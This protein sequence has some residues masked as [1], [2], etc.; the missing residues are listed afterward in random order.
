LGQSHKYFSKKVSTLLRN[1]ANYNAA[2]VSRDFLSSYST[3]SP[4]ILF[5]IVPWTTFCPS[6]H[7]R[8]L[9]AIL[10]LNLAEAE[11]TDNFKFSIIL[12]SSFSAPTGG[13]IPKIGGRGNRI[14]QMLEVAKE[15]QLKVTLAKSESLASLVSG[16]SSIHPK[17]PQG[18]PSASVSV[19]CPQA[20]YLLFYSCLGQ[21]LGA[22]L[23]SYYGFQLYSLSQQC[24]TP[25]GYRN[26][27]P[28]PRRCLSWARK[29]CSD[30]N[31]TS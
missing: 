29:L 7:T 25:L 18:T 15:Q 27:L 21:G 5:D 23:G 6:L 16:P 30:G 2:C 26:L 22:N 24:L 17:S 28:P 10:H 13:A 11:P 20:V 31:L 9:R 12:V 8:G 19:R 4:T 3:F 14:F 1:Q